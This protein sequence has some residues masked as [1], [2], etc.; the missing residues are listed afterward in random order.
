MDRA[1]GS[2]S[3]SHAVDDDNKSTR[4]PKTIPPR[5]ICGETGSLVITVRV[6]FSEWT[7]L[8]DFL[9]GCA[10]LMYAIAGG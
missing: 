2:E 5:E 8:F 7:T 6:G 1:C 3:A 10:L 9:G 4:R